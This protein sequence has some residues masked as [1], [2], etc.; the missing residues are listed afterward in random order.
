MYNGNFTLGNNVT[1][2]IL[3]FPPGTSCILMSVY[4]NMQ[5]LENT[6]KKLQVPLKAGE[7]FQVTKR[8]IYL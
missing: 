6:T 7:N 5:G 1:P 4:I 2:R 3:T 8:F